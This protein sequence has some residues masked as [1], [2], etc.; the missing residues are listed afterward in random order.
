MSRKVLII[1]LIAVIALI[2]IFIS[3]KASLPDPN[4]ILLSGN[5][6]VTE[7]EVSFKIPGKVLQRFVNEG[8][9]V[10]KN[11][12]IAKLE[13]EE[14][15][16]A[17]KLKE[18]ELS[19]ANAALQELTEGYLPEEIAQA[20][21][22]LKQAEANYARLESDYGRQKTLFEG[23]VISNREFDM[24]ISA[25][26]V[27]KAKVSEAQEKLTLLKRGIRKEKIA[28]AE[29]NVSKA[30]QSLALANT[31]LDYSMITS[32]INGY[33]LSD[34][35]EA[36][37]YVFPGTPIV[38]IGNLETVWLRA[39]IDEADLGKIKLG[40]D[41]KVSVDSYPDKIFPGK[42][43][44]ISPQAE[45]TP[46]NVQTE[47]ERVKLVYRVKIDIQNPDL[48]LKPGMPA[49]GIISLNEQPS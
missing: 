17:T 11:G 16:Q 4:T 32:P 45:F 9:R 48:E 21:A 22:R 14:L 1:P 26:E 23:D 5:I 38:T 18:A 8:E 44:F 19:A 7:V 27:A 37:E 30:K 40:Q 3:Q 29:A 13:P 12:E 24:S 20:G 47:K 25:Y 49:D 36:G 31:K 41:V 46:K 34:N 10:T 42:V 6:E 28:Q 43:S 33:I 35:I 39:Y 15:V 2:A